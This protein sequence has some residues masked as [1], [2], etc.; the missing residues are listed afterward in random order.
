MTTVSL[1][2][3]GT[4][5]KAALVSDGAVVDSFSVPSR[6]DDGIAKT[7]CAIEPKISEWRKTADV[8]GI[9]VAFPGLVDP[10]EKRVISKE[11]K[12]E[13][14]WRFDFPGWARKNFGLPLVLENDALA[15]ALGEYAFGAARGTDDF[16]LLILG[17]GIGTAAFMDGKPVRGKHFQAGITM[18]HTP[19]GGDRLCPCCGDA[20]CSESRAS[21]R[22]LGDLIA[23]NPGDS[24]L[25]SEPHPDFEL[26]KRY[27]DGGDPLA[28]A[29]FDECCSV[30]E[31]VILTLVLAYDP[32]LVV[33]SGGVLKWGSALSDRLRDGVLRRAWTTWGKLRFATAGDPDASVLLGLHKLAA[34]NA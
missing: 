2:P 15:A 26:L 22:A 20:G 21:T 32:E 28:A 8:G 34:E 7:L 25:K 24:P 4:N 10:V 3:G 16:V 1:D 27:C 31:D 29:V 12:Y 19:R 23:Q 5:V 13:D 18:G 30:W 9:G 6:P 11:G 33:L 14:A 17:T